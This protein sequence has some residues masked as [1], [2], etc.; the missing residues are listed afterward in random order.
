[1]N[2]MTNTASVGNDTLR[3]GEHSAPSAVT[4]NDREAGIALP[5]TL[6][7]L[8]AMTL[9]AIATLRTTTME[10]NMTANSRLRQI[11]FNTAEAALREAE[12]NI[13][14]IRNVRETFF[15][16]GALL[17]NNIAP[18]NTCD[19]LLNG[20]EDPGGYCLPAEL[21]YSAPGTRNAAPAPARW[22]DNGPGGLDVWNVAGRHSIFKN[23]L[24]SQLQREGVIDPP[25]YIIE[26][27]GNFDYRERNGS[28][29]QLRPRYS[30]A[31]VGNCR[32]SGNNELS[33]PS[34]VWPYCAAD[35]RV[36]RITIQATAGPRARQAQVLLQSFFRDNGSTGQ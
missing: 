29:T 15:G 32:Q 14:Q 28:A 21:T 27:M 8:L 34:D 26:F 24:D 1:M 20:T 33:P 19:G 5:L 4:L 12:L 11:A 22:K 17:P 30:G 13:S 7:L 36:F 6:I 3:V 10:E 35:S 23:L 18:G 2:K 16:I 25:K 9:I 31:F